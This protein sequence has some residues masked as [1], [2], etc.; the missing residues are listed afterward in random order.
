M[1]TTHPG[2]ILRDC[3]AS[4]ARIRFV[5]PDF[6]RTEHGWNRFAGKKRSSLTTLKKL[7]LLSRVAACKP[8][9]LLKHQIA[10]KTE[11]WDVRCPGFTEIDLVSHSGN[12]GAGEGVS[13][14]SPEKPK[15]RNCRFSDRLLQHFSFL[16]PPSSPESAP[17]VA[18]TSRFLRCVR[19]GSAKR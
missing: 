18:H 4:Y 7:W 17:Q 10:V 13:I 3:W 9:L 19:V 5:P 14:T 8:G 2:T 11:S 1:P 12:S 6:C 16:Q 15:T